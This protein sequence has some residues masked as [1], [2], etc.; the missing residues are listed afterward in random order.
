MR[1]LHK[2]SLLGPSTGMTAR[3]MGIVWAPNLLRSPLQEFS[4][5]GVAIQVR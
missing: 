4:L 2:M 1:H 5:S 3:N